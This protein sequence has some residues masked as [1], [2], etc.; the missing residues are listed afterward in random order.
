[1][2]H[3]CQALLRTGCW[4]VNRLQQ[5]RLL[6]SILL[7]QRREC[8]NQL[9]IGRRARASRLGKGPPTPP[10]FNPLT[11]MYADRA[12]AKLTDERSVGEP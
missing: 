6:S 7:R 12:Q 11:Y 5:D 8:C 9:G 4:L 2:V 3:A 1:M 10:S